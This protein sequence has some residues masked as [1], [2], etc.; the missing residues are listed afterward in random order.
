MIYLEQS[1]R[2]RIADLLLPDVVM[3]RADLEAKFPP[4]SE[5]VVT[6]FAPSPTGYLH[7]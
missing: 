2:D 4:R 3:T 1:A 7:V 6:R 5:S